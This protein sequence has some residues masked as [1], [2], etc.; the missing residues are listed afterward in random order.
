MVENDFV[1]AE[2]TAEAGQ[3][4][5]VMVSVTGL[6]EDSAL[7]S[8]VSKYL[9]S[10]TNGTIFLV[11]ARMLWTYFWVALVAT[12]KPKRLKATREVTRRIVRSID[13]TTNDFGKREGKVNECVEWVDKESAA[14]KKAN[15]EGAISDGI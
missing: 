11:N 12:D 2:S 10:K 14:R 8:C 4:E 15:E 6:Q 13:G 3:I 9:K 7:K 5:T 1:V